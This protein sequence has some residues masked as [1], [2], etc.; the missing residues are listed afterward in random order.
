MKIF[1]VGESKN[2]AM[3]INAIKKELGYEKGDFVVVTDNQ[4]EVEAITREFDVPVFTGDLFYEK[5]YLELGLDKADVVI[6]A[7]D[8]D[9][10]NVFVSMLAKE[11]R[12]PKIIA[13][14]SNSFVGR[15]L[16]SY[17]IATEVIE[18]AKELG[19]AVLAKV[20]DTH[21]VDVGD[22][23]ILVHIVSSNS[24]ILSKTIG[25]LE[26]EGLKVVA[27]VKN[28][29]IAELK[30][31]TVVELGDVVIVFG[32]KTLISKLFGG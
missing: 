5:L 31:D 10:V 8:N 22:K 1:I 28:G 11:L 13:I 7:H 15:F 23:S 29:V 6:A 18:K 17:G 14:V 20:F 2:I 12:I 9:M 25:D 21:F 19:W 16:K 30:H 4:E 3:V 32:D 27:V 24:R 26:N